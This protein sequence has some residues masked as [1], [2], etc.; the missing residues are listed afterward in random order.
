[1]KKKHPLE[2]KTLFLI[3]AATALIAVSF[4]L[5][6]PIFNLTI[7][8]TSST[9]VNIVTVAFDLGLIIVLL[10][11][12]SVL[13]YAR[14]K[15]KIVVM[16]AAIIF[17]TLLTI[18]LQ[19]GIQRVRP[20]TQDLLLP[21]SFPSLHAAVVFAAATMLSKIRWP[22]LW[23]ELATLISIGQVYILSHYLSDVV[24]GAMMGILIATIIYKRFDSQKRNLARS[25]TKRFSTK[26]QQH[27]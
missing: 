11:L 1:M 9:L 10:A 25:K 2:N 3:I 5:D 18:T 16:W 23:Y 20:F 19:F 4:L 14:Y 7:D 13:E 17:A 24:V 27:H 6:T 22:A 26:W 8:L 21:W 15:K 12:L